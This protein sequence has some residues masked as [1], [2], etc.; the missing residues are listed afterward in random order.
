MTLDFVDEKRIF[1]NLHA[2]R[3]KKPKMTQVISQCNIMAMIAR[4]LKSFT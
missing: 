4:S 3:S 1:N 2:S